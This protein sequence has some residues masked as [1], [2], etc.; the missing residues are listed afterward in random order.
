MLWWHIS[1]AAKTGQQA[2]PSTPKTCGIHA[3]KTRQG[4]IEKATKTGHNSTSRSCWDIRMVYQLCTSTQSK[5][6]SKVVPR[7][8]M[9]VQALIRPVNRGPKLNDILPE[10]NNMKH[11]SLIDVSS[12]YHNLKLDEISSYMIFTCQFGRYR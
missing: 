9:A 8:S 5:W 1:V 7:P 6:E 12:R 3:T 4:G 11:L 10:L 2:I